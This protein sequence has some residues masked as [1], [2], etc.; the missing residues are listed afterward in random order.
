[1]GGRDRAKFMTGFWERKRLSARLS[2]LGHSIDDLRLS[3]ATSQPNSGD[4]KPSSTVKERKMADS[5]CEVLLP[6]RSNKDLLD[7]YKSI[8]GGIRVE[9]IL[10]DLDCL[11]ASIAYL[12][13]D[14]YELTIV[15]AAVDQIDLLL[16]ID[17]IISDIRMK[18]SVTFVGRSSIEVTISVECN[19]KDERQWE[20]AAMAK[21]IMA[22]RNSEGTA[23]VQVNHL[24]LQNPRVSQIFEAGKMRR[25]WRLRRDAK[26][27]F[28]LPPTT[29]ESA[30]VHQICVNKMVPIAC[31]Y[32]QKLVPAR[33]TKIDALRI[34]HPQ[35]RNIHNY[36]FGG[37]LCREAFEL[38]FANALLFF[39]GE[40][41]R[42]NVIDENNFVL[43]VPIGS[44]VDYGSK[45]VYSHIIDGYNYAAVEVVA[46]ITNPTT[47]ERMTTNTF[48]FIMSCPVKPGDVVP[49]ILP[50][51]YMEAMKFLEGKRRMNN[52]FSKEIEEETK[53]SAPPHFDP[54]V[55]IPK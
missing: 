53:I 15:T 14:N 23:S 24:A 35:E 32:Q 10:E 2:K 25:Q 40:R 52:F 18:G 33:V 43:P 11:A 6:F 22:A 55:D 47:R 50:E 1:M 4:S 8:Y 51:T 26:S 38:G 21:F 5:Y 3:A 36:M 30:L 41:P 20:L 39:R 31:G 49:C 16:P 27:L 34:C 12:H 48:R 44:L 19:Q 28:L 46:D 37:Y 9:K 54:M 29:D 42:V 13:C 7:D 45:V 17:A